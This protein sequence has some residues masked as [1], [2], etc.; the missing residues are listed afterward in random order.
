MTSV[1]VRPAER[2]DL[3]GIQR[4][5]Y[6]TWHDTYEEILDAETIEAALREWYD[7]ATLREAVDRDDAPFLVADADDRVVGYASATPDEDPTVAHLGAIY[8]ERERW[9][10]GLGTRLLGH[11]Y[12]ALDATPATELHLTVLDDNEPARAFY[13]AR[14]FTRE[15]TR[16]SDLFGET[17]VETVYVRDLP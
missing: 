10:Q 14:G 15:S 8:V 13:E 2:A 5:A 4:V 12:E 16:E 3:A 17:V 1:T 6:E 11:L 7:D 9:R